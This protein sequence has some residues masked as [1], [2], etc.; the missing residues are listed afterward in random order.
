MTSNV[1]RG[2]ILEKIGPLKKKL[3]SNEKETGE[4]IVN[5]FIDL[6]VKQADGLPLYVKYVIGDVLANHYR[7]LDGNEMLPDSLHDYHEKLINGLGIGD[8]KFILTP[9]VALLAV[10]FEPL[11]LNE[12]ESI[13]KFR[14]IISD[15]EKGKKLVENG[16]SVIASMLRRAP[17][18]EG[19]EGYTLFHYSLREHILKSH[20]MANSVQTAKEALCE[21]AMKPDEYEE[22][23]NYLYRTGI[24][25]FIDLRKFKIAGRAL[26]NFYWL[27]NLFNLGKTPYDING[28]WSRLPISSRQM[29]ACYISK[30]I[31][32]KM[33]IGYGRTDFGL[34]RDWVGFMENEIY[35]NRDKNSNNEI[36]DY[37]VFDFQKNQ[38]KVMISKSYND[39][40]LNN[41]LDTSLTENDKKIIEANS[42]NA[43]KMNDPDSVDE[44]FDKEFED[45][46]KG[47]DDTF[48]NNFSTPNYKNFKEYCEGEKKEYEWF[49]PMKQTEARLSF[50]LK[51]S[52]FFL[53]S[54]LC[55]SGVELS[56]R[57]CRLNFCKFGGTNTNSIL[58]LDRLS[59]FYA[60]WDGQAA[61]N[62]LNEQ[63][64][65]YNPKNKNSVYGNHH[66]IDKTLSSIAPSIFYYCIKFVMDKEGLKSSL[67][68]K[69]LSNPCTMLPDVMNLDIK[70]K[71]KT[72]MKISDLLREVS[73]YSVK[74]R[75][76][77]HP[78]S[79]DI[80]LNLA[81]R[82]YFDMK[83]QEA[84]LIIEG[85]NNDF[86]TLYGLDDERTIKSLEIK[87]NIEFEKGDFKSAKI[88]FIKLITEVNK[89]Y[90]NDTILNIWRSKLVLIELFFQNFES[91]ENLCHEGLLYFDNP[92]TDKFSSLSGDRIFILARD[93]IGELNSGGSIPLLTDGNDEEQLKQFISYFTNRGLHEVCLSLQKH[94][95]I[96][97]LIKKKEILKLIR[98]FNLPLIFSSN[99][100][101]LLSQMS[102]REERCVRMR[103]GLGTNTTH[104]L[105][106]IALQFTVSVNEIQNFIKNGF[107][108][109]RI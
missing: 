108:K 12:I 90:L 45:L 44:T 24:D 52:D 102:P 5:P 18:P 95:N 1:I 79:L 27:F 100:N 32:N 87:G 8:L 42:E 89:K 84:E 15:D 66:V 85:V 30:L 48:D 25:H 19:E 77:K 10:T 96:H 31:D 105:D 11:S 74:S 21:L 103:Y 98:S 6:V 62:K 76:E 2:M 14:K 7:V 56:A 40:T 60:L 4:A 67:L 28:Y 53:L 72:L 16:L 38:D 23:T 43:K 71:N 86:F 80:K 59:S 64:L 46:L 92:K 20:D 68:N 33:H 39:K 104:S 54:R 69:L 65:F 55:H 29:D 83:L 3:L 36:N 73:D 58:A 70:S 41:L 94:Q 47:I 99:I 50:Y 37:W 9:L 35:D 97:K 88:S 91:V 22:L 57:I 26:L 107:K 75:G 93:L 34:G 51:L 13:L 63:H 61:D 109:L 106:E 82:L 101:N 78:S 17:D 49:E 81:N